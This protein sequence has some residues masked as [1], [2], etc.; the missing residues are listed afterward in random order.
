MRPLAPRRGHTGRRDRPGL[1]LGA[2]LAVV[3]LVAGAL[4]GLSRVPR[5]SAAF[6][7][8]TPPDA[9]TFQSATAWCH[10]PASQSVGAD[11]DAR[12]MSQGANANNN[13]GAADLVV[14]SRPND[15][16]RVLLHF[17]VSAQASLCTITSAT[18]TLQVKTFLGGRTYAVLALAAA[19]GE[20]TVTWNNQPGTTGTS[21]SAATTSPTFSVDVK[22]PVKAMLANGNRGLELFDTVESSPTGGQNTYFSRETGTAPVLTLTW[23]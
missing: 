7:A 14:E 15:N 16:Q 23:T 21:A 20:S 17:P 19:F 8:S 22:V 4:V 3:A 6:T 10:G 12:I 1:S 2:V 5:T 11:A 13:F 18:L 9:S